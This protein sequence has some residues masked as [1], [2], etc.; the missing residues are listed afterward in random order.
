ME[1]EGWSRRDAGAGM[2]RTPCAPTFSTPPCQGSALQPLPTFLLLRLRLP[3]QPKGLSCSLTLA[4]GMR[5]KSKRCWEQPVTQPPAPPTP[6]PSLLFTS[7]SPVASPLPV[8]SSCPSLS[9]N[10]ENSETT[11]NPPQDT[12]REQAGTRQ[13]P[14][15][16]GFSRKFPSSDATD[17]SS[18]HSPHLQAPAVAGN[19]LLV[20]EN[21]R[22]SRQPGGGFTGIFTSG[23]HPLQ[24]SGGYFWR[25][26]GTAG[27]QRRAPFRSEPAR[28]TVRG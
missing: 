8:P 14:E 12:A 24:E 7:L 26:A 16:A 18:P 22:R 4:P 19:A 20:T 6:P 21:P 9:Q 5:F 25:A 11:S 3:E 1:R 15:A 17:L 13:G 23:F 10:K 2:Q 27:A 28:A